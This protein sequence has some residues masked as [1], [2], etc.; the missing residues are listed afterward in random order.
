MLPSMK[1]SVP[2][3]LTGITLVTPLAAPVIFSKSDC[4]V[5]LFHN[6]FILTIALFDAE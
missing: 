6:V 2:F 4:E 5:L 1:F 3:A